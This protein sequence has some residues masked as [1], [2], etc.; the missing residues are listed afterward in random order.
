MLPPDPAVEMIEAGEVAARGRAGRCVVPRL[1]D[2]QMS[3]VSVI[4]TGAM[5]SALV[6][7]LKASGA[8]VTVWNRTKEKAEALSGP[9]VRLAGR[10][11]RR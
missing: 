7:G 8:R 1:G 5:G 2:C 11:A 9:R 6:E 4:G 3:N 10:W